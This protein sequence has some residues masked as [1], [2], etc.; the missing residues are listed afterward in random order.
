M[1]LQEQ[2]DAY[3]AQFQARAPKAAQEI[4]HRA[5]GDLRRSG[6]LARVPKVGDRAPG[7]TLPNI[8]GQSVSSTDLL[9]RGPLIVSFYR[10]KW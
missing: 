5:T 6:I 1:T 8:A 9:A 3:K 2:L 7:F 10:G 4:M